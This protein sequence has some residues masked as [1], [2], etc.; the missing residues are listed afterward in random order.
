MHKF[1]L[2][3]EFF[4]L[5]TPCSCSLAGEW[6]S[7]FSRPDCSVP[8]IYMGSKKINDIFYSCFSLQPYLYIIII[9]CKIAEHFMLSTVLQINNTRDVEVCI[10]T[11]TEEDRVGNN[12]FTVY[13]LYTVRIIH[14][15][16]ACNM[17]YYIIINAQQG[18]RRKNVFKK[19]HYSRSTQC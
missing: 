18:Q 6:D 3:D 16:I 10:V 7:A 9:I 17:Q 19:T 11:R 1:E 4:Q 13:T 2:D 8:Y 14:V 5:P 12:R 15:Y